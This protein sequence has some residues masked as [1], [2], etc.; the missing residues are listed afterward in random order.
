[1]RETLTANRP[2][3]EALAKLLLDK[4]VVTADALRAL[5]RDP[6]SGAAAS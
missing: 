2:T 5:L 6:A 4:E 3:L 1:V